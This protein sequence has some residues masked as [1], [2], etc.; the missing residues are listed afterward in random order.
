MNSTTH[1]ADKAQAE[2]SQADADAL[3]LAYPMHEIVLNLI[4]RVEKPM[5]R[6]PFGFPVY[7]GITTFSGVVD[8]LG[9]LHISG[10]DKD[11]LTVKL[12]ANLHG[13]RLSD[14]RAIRIVREVSR[15]CHEHDGHD[16]VGFDDLSAA[17]DRV[18]DERDEALRALDERFE[19]RVMKPIGVTAEQ[20]AEVLAGVGMEMSQ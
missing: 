16:A 10:I 1:P 9:N 19:P 12:L 20:K 18:L 3:E 8:D 5:P 6:S 13:R 7:Q 2:L 14:E 4:E 11:E 15:V 17:I